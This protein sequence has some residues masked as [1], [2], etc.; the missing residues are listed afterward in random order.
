MALGRLGPETSLFAFR[1]VAGVPPWAQAT[2]V[3]A[4]WVTMVFATH[5]EYRTKGTVLGYTGPAS[6]ILFVPIFEEL[7]FRG[8][9]LGSLARRHSNAFAIVASALLF[10]LWHLKNIYWMETGALLGQMGY[11]GLLFGPVAGWLT[12]KCRSVWPAVILH[13]VNNLQAGY[14]P[15]FR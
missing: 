8:W 11:T 13:F 12:L 10:G 3:V 6:L 5:H 4:L 9:M 14:F 1:R 15:L 2:A 7:I